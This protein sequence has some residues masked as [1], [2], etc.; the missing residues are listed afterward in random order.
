MTMR[1]GL[2]LLRKSQA[3]RFRT[4]GIFTMVHELRQIPAAL[5]RIG[6]SI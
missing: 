3:L 2:T 1:F 4:G 6:R 5:R